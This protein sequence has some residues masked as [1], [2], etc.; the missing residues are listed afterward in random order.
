MIL[1]QEKTNY[2]IEKY[3]KMK[4][5]ERGRNMIADHYLYSSNFIADFEHH[6]QHLASMQH[7]HLR[8]VRVALALFST[9]MRL[10]LGNIV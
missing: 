5:I 6:L 7:F 9:K 2:R 4:W 10:G 3:I 8:S 1:K